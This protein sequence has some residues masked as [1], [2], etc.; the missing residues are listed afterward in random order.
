MRLLLS[1][2]LTAKL[3]LVFFLKDTLMQI[4]KSPYMFAFIQKQYPENLAFLVLTFLE[5]FALEGKFVNFLT[6][7]LIFNI[8]YCFWMF[9][10]KLFTYLSAHISESKR[11]LNVKSLAYSFHMKTK[12]SGKFQISISV[13][14]TFENAFP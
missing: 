8:F 2:S 7:R 1:V 6:S 4:G 9:L 12:I 3:E 14:L 13:A 10:N 11:C 5:L